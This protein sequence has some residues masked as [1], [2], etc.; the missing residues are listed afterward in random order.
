VR[1]NFNNYEVLGKEKS[2]CDQYKQKQKRVRKQNVRLNP[3]DYDQTE[4][5]V[6][7]DS[8]KFR[9]ECYIPVIDQLVMS[10]TQRIAA[11][12]KSESYFGFLRRLHSLSFEEIRE[13]A[14]KLIELYKDDLEE[15]LITELVQFKEFSKKFIVSCEDKDE[16]KRC[17]EA[18]MY[19]LIIEKDLQ[20]IFSNTCIVLKIYLILM[21][22]NCTSER[23]FSKLKLIKN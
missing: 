20:E 6:L 9:I 3:L 4:N 18:K 2:E 14:L 16:E 15:D 22:T 19:K 5:I 1:D 21:T 17:F 13:H 11:Y 10:L 7:T 23:A 12:E 8:Q